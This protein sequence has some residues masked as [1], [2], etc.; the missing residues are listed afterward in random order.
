[1]D[2]LITTMTI[3]L[4]SPQSI[5]RYSS[6]I[7]SFDQPVPCPDCGRNTRKHGFY[8]RTVHARK[9]S[10]SIKILRRRCANCRTTHALIPSF[11]IPWGRFTNHIR[12]F[13]L[14]YLGAG[15][16]VAHLVH[17]LT[18]LPMSP[19]SLKTLYRWKTRLLLRVEKW[20]IA[21]RQKLAARYDQDDGILDLYRQGIASK[22]EFH[23]LLIKAVD[24]QN[25]VLRTGAIFSFLNLQFVRQ[26]MYW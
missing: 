15:Y 3:L 12:E 23:L 13:F 1:M 21:E 6:F 22:E 19:L 20:W 9:I 18:E 17:L 24:E 8:D 14:W 2:N 16:S 26:E 10:H 5:K 25:Q 4:E 11:L 7:E